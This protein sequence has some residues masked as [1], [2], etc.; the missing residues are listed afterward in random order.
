LTGD[1]PGELWQQGRT[2]ARPFSCAEPGGGRSRLDRFPPGSND[3]VARLEPVVLGDGVQHHPCDQ[4]DAPGS[5]SQG[6]INS[7]VLERLSGVRSPY[8]IAKQ[9]GGLY[10]K[11]ILLAPFFFPGGGRTRSFPGPTGPQRA[12][13]STRQT[14][15]GWPVPARVE[16]HAGR[17]IEARG[18]RK[19]G[20]I[21][22]R[23]RLDRRAVRPAEA[24]T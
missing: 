16:R 9:A 12:T 14:G 3:L 6:A 19:S 24:P 17:Q 8:S 20:G 1:L 18:G 22:I 13:G 4:W 10:I 11:Q 7:K 2:V 15:A 21:L 5:D 23:E